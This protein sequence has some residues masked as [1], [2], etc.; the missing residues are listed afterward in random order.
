MNV[1]LRH[2]S[3]S[4]KQPEPS[5]LEYLFSY[6]SLKSYDKD[7]LFGYMIDFP[8]LFCLLEE[9]VNIKYSLPENSY[10]GNR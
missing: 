7:V 8:N 5:D 9:Q 4:L 10:V 6:V 3:L 1:R 2:I